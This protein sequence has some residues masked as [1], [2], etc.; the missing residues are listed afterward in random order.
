MKLAAYSPVYNEEKL[1][2][3]AIKSFAPFVDKHIVMIA[4]KPFYGT[5]EP[6]DHTADVAADLGA[7]PLFTMARPEHKMRNEAMEMLD[8]GEYDWILVNDA[9]MWFEHE[10]IRQL[11]TVLENTDE[12][13][14]CMPQFGYWKDTDHILVGD[15]FCPVVALRPNRR[16]THIGNANGAYKILDDLKLHHLAW[17]APKDILKKVTTYSHAPEFD[18]KP[19]YEQYYLGWKEG[20]K[21]VLPNKRFDVAYKPLP[22]E[23]KAYLPKEITC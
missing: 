17:C 14:V 16:F 19:W 4:T 2:T 6:L 9:D 22:N 21:A 23:L 18:G 8:N 3:G 1:I 13:I 15:D 5:P 11:I 20:Q 10:N 7:V 12:D